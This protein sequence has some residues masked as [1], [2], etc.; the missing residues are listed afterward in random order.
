MYNICRQHGTCQ[1]ILSYFQYIYKNCTCKFVCYVHKNSPYVYKNFKINPTLKNEYTYCIVND[2]LEYKN[3]VTY[4][5]QG[6]FII[7]IMFRCYDNNSFSLFQMRYSNCHFSPRIFEHVLVWV[8]FS[9]VLIAV[10][11]SRLF[12]ATH[13][14]QQVV[15]GSLTGTITEESYLYL[16]FVN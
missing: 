8:S 9:V 3:G 6:S 5:L 13:F 2:K 12:I 7:I 4:S 11:I 10:N 16:A 15:A 14:P 1:I